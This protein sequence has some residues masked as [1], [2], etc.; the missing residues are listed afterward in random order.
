M[1]AS[2]TARSVEGSAFLDSQSSTAMPRNGPPR[3]LASLAETFEKLP[4]VNLVTQ[5]EM[6]EPILTQ[7]RDSANRFLEMINGGDGAAKAA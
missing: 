1:F 7:V 6:L 2:M 3:T 4:A 5:A